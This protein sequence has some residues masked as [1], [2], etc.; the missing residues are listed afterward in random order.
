MP[1]GPFI[2]T[3][4][5]S[6]RGGHFGVSCDSNG[7]FV[8]PAPLLKRPPDCFGRPIWRPRPTADVNR[9]LSFCYGLPVDVTNKTS[10]LAAVARALN[11][12]AL[13]RAQIATLHLRL[14]DLPRLNDG[15]PMHGRRVALAKALHWSGLLKASPDD[16]EH[17]GWP[18]G[19]PGGQGGK[20]RPKDGE[21]DGFGEPP[22]LPDKEPITERAKN[23]IRKAVAVWLVRAATVAVSEPHARAALTALEVTVATYEWLHPYVDAYRSPPKTLEELEQAAQDA[24]GKTPTGYDRHHI[25]EQSAARAD[26]FS[27]SQIDEKDNVVLISRLKHWEINGWF[28]TPNEDYG[29]QSPR[30]Y[31]QGRSWDE[32]RQ[33]G[34]KALIKYGVLKP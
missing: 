27:E 1:D 34:L 9:D 10:G 26:G 5:L 6:S 7:V 2:R 14:P 33:V 8:G 31:L 11:D 18:K 20:F 23:L 3:F 17:P 28:Q 12:G 21:G 22:K 13:V 30:E 4:S 15:M 16:P 29:G 32:R 19:A 25:V 24:A